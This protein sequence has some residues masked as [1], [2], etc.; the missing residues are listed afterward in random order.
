MGSAPLLLVR[1]RDSNRSVFT[2][3]CCTRYWEGEKLALTCANQYSEITQFAQEIKQNPP[4]GVAGRV[5]WI[6]AGDRGAGAPIGGCETWR[7]F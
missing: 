1:G 5:A 2:D 3:S 6:G 7:V 4:G